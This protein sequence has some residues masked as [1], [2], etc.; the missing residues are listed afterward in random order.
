M[1]A[2]N[3]SSTAVGQPA[4]AQGVVSPE[5]AAVGHEAPDQAQ[6]SG[7]PS[8]DASQA[9]AGGPPASAETGWGYFPPDLKISAQDRPA[10]D[11]MANTMRTQGVPTERGSQLISWMTELDNGPAPAEQRAHK[12]EVPP[13]WGDD[14]LPF[15]DAYLNRAY[16]AGWSQEDVDRA[17]RWYRTE[18]E[19]GI[20]RG[21]VAEERATAARDASDAKAASKAL[22]IEWG[23]EAASNL[24]VLRSY[25]DSLP[26]AEREALM[27]KELPDGRLALNDPAT[28]QALVR[29]AR[30]APPA[31]VEAAKKHGGDDLAAL[32]EM[33]KNRSGPYWK[34]RDAE[35]LQARYRDLLRGQ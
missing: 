33:M 20:K 15:L 5:A 7:L 24:R 21:Q 11:L 30:A 17:I 2:P 4:G 14:E 29:K 19:P 6:G 35:R 16:S 28:V 18:I 12:Y 22:R 8:S 34:G 26:A 13:G 27:H 32:R 23:D 3:A 10:Y 25:V 31:L 1:S 9:P